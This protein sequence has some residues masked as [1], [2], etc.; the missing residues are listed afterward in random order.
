M[1]WTPEKAANLAH[2]L[3]ETA[4]LIERRGPACLSDNSFV[5]VSLEYVRASDSRRVI[6][7]T[8]PVT[9]AVTCNI[10]IGLT[11]CPKN[12][13]KPARVIGHNVIVRWDG[14]PPRPPK[15]GEYYNTVDEP[16]LNS[17]DIYKCIRARRKSFY[18]YEPI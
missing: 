16:E 18:I 8:E 10:S 12:G 3:R 15:K 2:A 14:N 5:S 17:P 9:Y 7:H 6:L 13:I 4:D 1:D 11:T